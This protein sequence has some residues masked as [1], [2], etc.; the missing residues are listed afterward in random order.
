[1]TIPTTWPR[2]M[3]KIDRYGRLA[4]GQRAAME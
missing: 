3:R 1:M 4:V 2:H